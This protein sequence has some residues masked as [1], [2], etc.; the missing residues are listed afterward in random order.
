MCVTRMQGMCI[1]F[2]LNFNCEACQQEK[3]QKG[4]CKIYAWSQNSFECE[5]GRINIL[6]EFG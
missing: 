2:G 4:S 1:I 5:K 6:L 3:C